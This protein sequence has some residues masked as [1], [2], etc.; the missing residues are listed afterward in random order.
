MSD[1]NKNKKSDKLFIKILSPVNPESN[2][3]VF[4]DIWYSVNDVDENIACDIC[5]DKD[6]EDEDPIFVCDGCNSAAHKN[7]YGRELIENLPNMNEN[8]FC[9]RCSHL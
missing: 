4:K 7:C 9:H 2:L 8:W 3:H 6:Y 1:Q 5:L